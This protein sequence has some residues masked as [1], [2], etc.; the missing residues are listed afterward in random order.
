MDVRIMSRG[1]K[2]K[3]ESKEFLKFKAR[4]NKGFK[5]EKMTLGELLNLNDTRQITGEEKRISGVKKR[6]QANINDGLDSS[7]PKK[8]SRRPFTPEIETPRQFQ[9]RATQ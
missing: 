6:R 1:F 7:R 2:N 4:P 9:P 5:I 3:T 8:S